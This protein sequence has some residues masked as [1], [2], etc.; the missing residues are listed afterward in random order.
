MSKMIQKIETEKKDPKLGSDLFSCPR[1]TT[2]IVHNS[3][4]FFNQLG[5]LQCHG[6]VARNQKLRV[7][8]I[9]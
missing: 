4:C 9:N 2:N 1:P 6:N 8:I 3:N 7:I 5:Y